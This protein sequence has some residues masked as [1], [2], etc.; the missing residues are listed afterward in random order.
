MLC[1]CECISSD[2]DGSHLTSH[3]Q[4]ELNVSRDMVSVMLRVLVIMNAEGRLHRQWAVPEE[5]WVTEQTTIWP[6]AAP[7]KVPKEE[8]QRMLVSRVQYSRVSIRHAVDDS[9]SNSLEWVHLRRLV[10]GLRDVSPENI[11]RD[12]C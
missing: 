5:V 1:R 2:E 12:V 6:L 7:K 10:F 4:P 8:A 3:V 11:G 9:G